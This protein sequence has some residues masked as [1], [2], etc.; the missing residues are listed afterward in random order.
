ML[1]GCLPSTVA[2]E[3]SHVQLEIHVQRVHGTGIFTYI[4]SMFY[5]RLV[6]K[7]TRF[8]DPMGEVITLPPNII[9]QYIQCLQTQGIC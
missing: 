2:M 9:I 6:G 8:M 1:A 5:G 7:Y 3:Y 4:W